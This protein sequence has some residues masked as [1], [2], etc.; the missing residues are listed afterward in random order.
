MILIN[1]FQKKVVY[2]EFKDWEYFKKRAYYKGTE[3]G[4][5]TPGDCALGK[6]WYINHEEQAADYSFNNWG[7]RGSEY[8]IYLGKPVNICVGDSYTVN[9]GGTIQDSWCS[10][11]AKNFKIPTINL[12]MDGAGNDAIKL[13]CERANELF[14]VQNTFIMYSFLH[15]RLRNNMFEQDVFEDEE[16]FLYLEKNIVK[17]AI[18]T[19]L[20]KWCFTENEFDYLQKNHKKN[21]YMFPNLV[22][23]ELSIKY[24]PENIYENLKVDD[25]VSYKNFCDGIVNEVM[26]DDIIY[27]NLKEQMIYANRDGLHLNKAANKIVANFLIESYKNR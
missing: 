17:D 21:L 8:N 24:I 5:D 1:T 12:G 11:L 9:V 25:W 3:Y 7:F 2:M 13:V 14:D 19:F 26:S 20:P 6:D 15:R 27:I 4:I 23:K 22:N 16:N 10:Q 18:Y